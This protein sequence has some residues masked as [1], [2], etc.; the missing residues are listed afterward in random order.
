MPRIPT[1]KPDRAPR[2]PSVGGQVDIRSQDAF[3][4]SIASASEEVGAIIEKARVEKQKSIDSKEANQVKLYQM[5]KASELEAALREADSS[6]HSAIID[7]STEEWKKLSFSS[8]VSK[9][10]KEALQQ[11]HN[12]WVQG[13]YSKSI[14]WSA[15]EAEKDKRRV[16]EQVYANS[17]RAMDFEGAEKSIISMGL[18][19]ELTEARINEARS[20]IEKHQLDANK[21]AENESDTAIG[22]MMDV[23]YEQGLQ[24]NL[25]LVRTD[26]M[27]KG[28]W[29]NKLEA[30][31][32]KLSN[33]ISKKK[34]DEASAEH[35]ASISFQISKSKNSNDIENNKAKINDLLNQGLISKEQAFKEMESNE[36]KARSVQ[37]ANATRLRDDISLLSALAERA[38]LGQLDEKTLDAERETF[39]SE[40]VDALIAV[41]IGASGSIGLDSP[42]Y[43]EAERKME[44]FIGGIGG[45]GGKFFDA[46]KDMLVDIGDIV[47]GN[48]TQSAKLKLMSTFAAAMYTDATYSDISVFARGGKTD[49]IEGDVDIDPA[50]RSYAKHIAAKVFEKAAHPGLIPGKIT[51]ETADEVIEWARQA[52]PKKSIISAEVAYELFKDFWNEEKI[53]SITKDNLKDKID[54]FDKELNSAIKDT[55]SKILEDASLKL[56]RDL[57]RN[58]RERSINSVN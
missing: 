42:E 26:S 29:S 4:R 16:A 10:Q 32:L 3:F 34:Q 30:D 14:S 43:L 35:I 57:S 44:N 50:Q 24:E 13:L 51:E 46:N 48:F 19:P 45:L 6:E 1:S 33:N 39:G 47:D 20:I 40:T 17:V 54:D 58:I 36:S 8:N 21:A 25:N 15:E 28:I 23:Y 12:L 49:M 9:E 18:S 27:K 55:S 22:E 2:R 53:G 11:D 52:K 5:E 31:Y 38:N 56:R 41:N 37:T 7:G